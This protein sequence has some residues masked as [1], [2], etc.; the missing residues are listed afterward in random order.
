MKDS[1]LIKDSSSSTG[2]R[3]TRVQARNRYLHTIKPIEDL[4]DYCDKEESDPLM[5]L[6]HSL[7]EAIK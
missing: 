2:Y 4:L 5:D 7:M 6:Y 1:V 3:M